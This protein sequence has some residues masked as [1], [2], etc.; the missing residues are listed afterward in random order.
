MITSMNVEIS[1]QSIVKYAK[2][3]MEL[4]CYRFVDFILDSFKCRKGIKLPP[5]LEEASYELLIYELESMKAE[6][7]EFLWRKFCKD[8]DII[9]E[10]I[11][12]ED[13]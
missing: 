12:M 3:T 2:K 9:E 4:K 11:R 6:V 7:E 1:E 13:E 5:K 10:K 8:I